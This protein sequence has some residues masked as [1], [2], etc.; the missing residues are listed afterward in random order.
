MVKL[1]VFSFEMV[2]YDGF[3]EASEKKVLCTVVI[4]K[5]DSKGR[6]VSETI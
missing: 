2:V 3:K 1:L 6:N 5:I 4:L